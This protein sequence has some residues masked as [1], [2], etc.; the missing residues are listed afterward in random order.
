MDFED[1]IWLVIAWSIFSGGLKMCSTSNDIEETATEIVQTVE[2]SEGVKDILDTAAKMLTD[3]AEEVDS[4]IKVTITTTDEETNFVKDTIDEH[5]SRETVQREEVLP[6]KPE[7]PEP[8]EQPEEIKT[9][10]IDG[11]VEVYDGNKWSN[12]M[13]YDD[14]LEKERK[15]KC[16]EW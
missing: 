1:I 15:E 14:F 5:E 10:C 9:R 12:Q 11:L 3:M 8:I 16:D 7:R 2:E 13:I 4:I 6:P